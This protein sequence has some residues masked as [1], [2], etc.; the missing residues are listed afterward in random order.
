M[1][2]EESTMTFTTSSSSYLRKKM[3][4]F[5]FIFCS[6][7]SSS[8]LDQCKSSM[9][10]S[11]A[12]ELMWN[13]FAMSYLMLRMLS[14]IETL[15]SHSE[16]LYGFELMSSPHSIFFRRVSFYMWL[17]SLIFVNYR[18]RGLVEGGAL[19]RNFFGMG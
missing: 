5:S 18:V 14:Q 11:A 9:T 6:T 2:L 1:E 15:L 16:S 12:S 17:S 13:Y 3:S 19:G 8:A 4:G 7:S 10:I